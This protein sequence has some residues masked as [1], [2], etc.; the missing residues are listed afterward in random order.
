MKKDC[1]QAAG[2]LQKVKSMNPLENSYRIRQVSF[3]GLFQILFVLIKTI[4]NVR[5]PGDKFVNKKFWE[6]IES[7]FS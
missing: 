1:P 7:L 6:T 3:Q 2:C 4:G 5:N